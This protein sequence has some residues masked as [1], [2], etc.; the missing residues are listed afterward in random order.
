M[1][2]EWSLSSF[3]IRTLIWCYK[4]DDC[5]PIPQVQWARMSDFQLGSRFRFPASCWV[6]S[7]RC[8]SHVVLRLARCSLTCRSPYQEN[9]DGYT[10][11]FR[12]SVDD[13]EWHFGLLAETIRVCDGEPNQMQLDW[14]ICQIDEINQI[15]CRLFSVNLTE[16]SPFLVVVM[17]DDHTV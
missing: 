11:P 7:S 5:C 1:D 13:P 4:I 2:D 14:F 16:R 3:Q 10:W 6:S 12:R 17:W 9:I 15:Q 8:T